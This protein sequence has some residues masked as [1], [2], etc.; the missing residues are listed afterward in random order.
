[1]RFC[2]HFVIKLRKS[3]KK[4]LHTRF[5]NVRG[6]YVPDPDFRIHSYTVAA[7]HVVQNADESIVIIRSI[8]N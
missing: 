8:N 5:L 2:P 7:M 1:M 3:F 6:A 4:V